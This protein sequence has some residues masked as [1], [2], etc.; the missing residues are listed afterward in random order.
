M[1]IN[2]NDKNTIT[3]PRPQDENSKLTQHR[4]I[5]TINDFKGENY[6]KQANDLTYRDKAIV[7]NAAN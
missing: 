7:S 3:H 4:D 2:S 1:E 5:A 6:E